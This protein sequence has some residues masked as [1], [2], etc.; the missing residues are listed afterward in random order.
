MMARKWVILHVRSLLAI[1]LMASLVIAPS[2]TGGSDSRN[3][4]IYISK[5]DIRAHIEFLASDLLEGRAPGTSGGE[6]AEDYVRSVYRMYG[7]EP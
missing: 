2:C 4:N 5:E 1:T 7:F 6:L 3:N